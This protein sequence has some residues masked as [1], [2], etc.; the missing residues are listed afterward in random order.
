MEYG[1]SFG[2]RKTMRRL[3]PIL[4][5]LLTPFSRSSQ[6][7]SFTTEALAVRDGLDADIIAERFEP[8]C[9]FVRIEPTFPKFA[10]REGLLRSMFVDDQHVPAGSND[11]TQF[12]DAAF[13]DEAVFQRLD[14]ERT[15]E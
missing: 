15:V 13:W 4:N 8:C 1:Y 10:F 3:V 6:K 9:Q 11:A 12:G 5:A 14:G 2:V 7:Q